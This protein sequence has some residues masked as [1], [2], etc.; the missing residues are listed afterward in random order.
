VSVVAAELLGIGYCAPVAAASP[1]GGARPF[2]W[3][4]RQQGLV[5]V[6]LAELPALPRSGGDPDGGALYRPPREAATPL[7]SWRPGRYVLEIH[8]ATAPSDRLWF[9]FRVSS[10]RSVKT[11]S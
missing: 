1:V 7:G 10:P 9:A 5:P 2:V 6:S 3:L 8:L 11:G 4:A